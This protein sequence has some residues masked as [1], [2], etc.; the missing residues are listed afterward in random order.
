MNDLVKL[1][2]RSSKIMKTINQVLRKY[3]CFV[4]FTTKFVN[5]IIL[6]YHKLKRLEST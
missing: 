1:M 2:F 4:G 6:I 5:L 3:S